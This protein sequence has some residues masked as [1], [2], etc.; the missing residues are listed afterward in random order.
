MTTHELRDII[1][2]TTDL[3]R[4]ATKA[5]QERDID[6]LENLEYVVTDWLQPEEEKDVQISLLNSMIEVLTEV[7]ELDD[8]LQGYEG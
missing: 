8:E 6:T 2:N 5:L 1:Y 4:I 7:E 3:I